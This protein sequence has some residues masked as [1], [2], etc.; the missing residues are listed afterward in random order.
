MLPKYHIVLM[1][2]LIGILWNTAYMAS[3]L[4][5]RA[6][7]IYGI[8]ILFLSFII[9]N[10]TMESTVNYLCSSHDQPCS[11]K[12]KLM[13]CLLFILILIIFEMV[14]SRLLKKI[15]WKYSR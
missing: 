9:P 3:K 6:G 8:I 14:A 13:Y 7:C 11:P 1:Y 10:T 12:I 5:T 15:K 2:I 4:G